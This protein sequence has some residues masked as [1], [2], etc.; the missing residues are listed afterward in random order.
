MRATAPPPID[1]AL[2]IVRDTVEARHAERAAGADPIRSAAALETAHPGEP[3]HRAA[4]NLRSADRGRHAT[5]LRTRHKSRRHPQTAQTNG[6]VRHVRGALLS[7]LI[8][9][10]VASPTITAKPSGPSNSRES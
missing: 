4:G 2:Q 10:A 8:V 5:P 3:S 6:V 1:C 9:K 7:M